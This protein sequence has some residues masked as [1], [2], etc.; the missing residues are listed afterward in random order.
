MTDPVPRLRRILNLI[1]LLRSRP[2]MSIQE[3]CD[4]LGVS[5]NELT[6]DLNRIFLCGV[7][8]YLPH[9][10]ILVN[11]DDD[12]VSLG[13]ADHFARPVRLTL[14]EALSLK[15]AIETLPPL[16]GELARGAEALL[17]SV[18]ALFRRHGLDLEALEGQIEVPASTETSRKL[19]VLQR[20]LEACRGLRLAYYSASSDALSERD[21]DP[22]A[23]ID[24][25]GTYY[26]I[27]FCHKSGE[28]RCFRVDRIAKILAEDG[29]AY[30]IP[31]DF[32]LARFARAIGP[33]IEE[34]IKVRARFD[35][36]IARWV[37]EDY[38]DEA[39]EEEQSGAL[40]VEFHTGSIPWAAQ[41]LLGYGELV[42]VL[43]PLA[44]RKE[45]IRRLREV[46]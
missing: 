27:A 34:A 39:I 14:R 12:K 10:Y 25:G 5:R 24:Q 7:P 6:G 23:L 22:Y 9:D 4:E 15:L 42:E 32:D 20:H 17:A 3:L 11:Q 16:S 28:T 37:R 8:P 29:P 38:A 41:K 45:M 40:L 2:G 1:P 35:A 31:E 46:A 36:G 43:E 30:A 26:L 33:S 44:L 21:L 13:F 19:A 18:N